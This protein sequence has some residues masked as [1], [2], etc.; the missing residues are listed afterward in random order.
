M[1]KSYTRI[2]NSLAVALGALL[3][4][5]VNLGPGSTSWG[6]HLLASSP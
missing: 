4:P 2:L 6:M 1:E 5:L 3:M